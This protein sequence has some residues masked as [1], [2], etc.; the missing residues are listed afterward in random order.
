MYLHHHHLLSLWS[1]SVIRLKL[2][3]IKTNKRFLIQSAGG[4]NYSRKSETVG[5]RPLSTQWILGQ[6]SEWKQCIILGGKD[7]VSKSQILAYYELV[8]KDFLATGRV[9]IYSQCEYVGDN[10]FKSLL[11]N[12]LE[13]EITVRKKTVDST[14]M[15]CRVPSITKP[16]FEIAPEITIVP[17]NGL[18]DIRSPW[19]KYVVLGAGKTGIDAILFLL[20]QNVEADK[21]VWIMP[22]DAWFMN[23]DILEPSMLHATIFDILNTLIR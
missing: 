4:W 1:V 21:I 19:E 5:W 3:K 13:Y 16:K 12:G 22:N 18:I 9:K 17:I 11:E 6:F 8:L 10:K 23:R 20:N 7:L 15:D 2:H 14:Y